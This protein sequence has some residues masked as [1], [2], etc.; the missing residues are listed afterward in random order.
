MCKLSRCFLQPVQQ[1]RM[2]GQLFNCPVIIDLT[3]CLKQ[4][5]YW[6]KVI[7]RPL[8]LRCCW[9]LLFLCLLNMTTIIMCFVP[10]ATNTIQYLSRF[11]KTRM[12]LV[13]YAFQLLTF[14]QDAASLITVP[15]LDPVLFNAEHI[16]RQ[17]YL[18]FYIL[19]RCIMIFS[20]KFSL[21]Y[22]QNKCYA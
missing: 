18:S 21:C 22:S 19:Q 6:L 2:V 17:I 14:N 10:C 11:L 13:C 20:C 5:K 16:S 7:F 15:P 8:C 1:G 3:P 9:S 4:A 12:W